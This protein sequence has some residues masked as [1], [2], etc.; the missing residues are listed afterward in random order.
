[1]PMTNAKAP[2]GPVWRSIKLGEPASR[3]S[4][5]RSSVHQPT[6]GTRPRGPSLDGAPGLGEPRERLFSTYTARIAYREAVGSDPP[7][8]P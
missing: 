7:M 4:R 8:R 3:Q 6:S 2:S 1:M 5:D